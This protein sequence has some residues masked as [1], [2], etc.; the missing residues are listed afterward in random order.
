M[1]QVIWPSIWPRVAVVGAGAVGCFFGAK[2]AKAGAAVTLIGRAPAMQ[3]IADHG[4][5]IIGQDYSET[6]RLQT[7]TELSAAADCDL[8]LLCVKTTDTDS[9]VKALAS[10]LKP[11]TAILSLQNGVDNV[12][13]IFEARGLRAIPAAVYVAVE[14]NAP[15]K[16]LHRGRGDLAIGAFPFQAPT[17]ESADR[18]TASALQ[19]IAAWFEASGVPCTVSDNVM[20]VLWAKFIVN[21]AVNAIS[22][23]TQAPYGRMLEQPDIKTLISAL[24]RETVAVAHAHGVQLKENDHEGVVFQVMKAMSAQFSST[25]Q[26][27][28]RGKPTEIDALNG[29]VSKIAKLHGLEAPLNAWLTAMVKLRAGQF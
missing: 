2:L 12:E 9:T 28:A 29:Y 5:E 21:C 6:V 4:L 20:G 15:G 23:L 18:I 24:V 27:L 25:A 11:D 7:S 26:D 14:M 10:H 17:D 13:R 16:L 1:S 3:A 19:N 22:A 8:I